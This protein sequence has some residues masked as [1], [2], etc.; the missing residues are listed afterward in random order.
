[1]KKS[2]FIIAAAALVVGCASKEV[3]N[4]IAPTPIG[5]TKVYIENGTRAFQTGAY[6]TTNFE[7]EG[8]TFAV[9][10]FKT[11]SSQTN[12]RVFNNVTVTYTSGLTTSTNG[13]GA[14]TDWAYSPLVYWDK[15]ATAYNFYAYAPD[16]SKFT[17]TAA[18][19]TDNDPTTFSI[20]GFQ[21]ATTQGDMIDLMT[22]MSSKGGTNSVTGNSIGTNDVEFTFTHI[23]SNINILMAVS[24][25]LKSDS[26]DNPVT[27]DSIEIGAIKMDGTYSYDNGYKWT[28]AN[29]P[30]EQTF[31]A[32]VTNNAVFASNE[33]KANSNSISSGGT[34]PAGSVGLDSVPSLTDLLFVPQALTAD[35]YKIWIKYQIDEE[36]F[37]KTISL[38]DFTN[39]QDASLSTW[40]PGY[41]YNYVLIIG[42]TPILFDI[43]AINDWGDG[44]TYTYTVE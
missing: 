9:Y 40:Q 39:N 20:S 16:D 10:G 13:Y 35:E 26:V 19:T 34:L 32:T 43:E 36:I 7:T 8:N 1:M 14:A 4:D 41:K 15:T 44:G 37:H 33:L 22:D 42:P 18:F 12:A 25:D 11:T 23:L 30:T 6:T 21:Q 24:A 38:S 3:K 28:L 29:S 17:G 5:F 27:V 2:L 31:E